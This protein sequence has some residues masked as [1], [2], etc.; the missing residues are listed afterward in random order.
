MSV[1]LGEYGYLVYAQNGSSVQKRDS[2]IM[3]RDIVEVKLEDHK[4]IQ[5]Y[6]QKVWRG[7]VGEFEAR[8]SMI[9]VFHVN[10]YV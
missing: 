10:Q 2:E 6:H 1:V 7:V 4:G 9:R 3:S 8:R 5:T